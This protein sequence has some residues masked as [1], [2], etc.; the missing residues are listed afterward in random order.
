MLYSGDATYV[1]V[2]ATAL[3]SA[4]QAWCKRTGESPLANL[5]FIAALEDRGYTRQR[6]HA[7]QYYWHGLG[8]VD[9][10]DERYEALEEG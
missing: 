5:A 1:K 4:Y 2:K 9:T 6:G 10:S 8:L 3:V 7:N